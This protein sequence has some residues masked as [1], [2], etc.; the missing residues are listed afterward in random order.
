MILTARN[1]TEPGVVLLGGTAIALFSPF[2][3]MAVALSATIVLLGFRDAPE[4]PADI[5]RDNDNEDNVPVND[6]TAVDH[7]LTKL[8]WEYS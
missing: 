5:V 8:G 7:T 1:A 3:G 2:V 6:A 4:G